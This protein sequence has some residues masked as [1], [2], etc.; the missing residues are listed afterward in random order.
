MGLEFT[1]NPEINAETVLLF[2]TIVG[3]VIGFIFAIYQVK[4]NQRTLKAQFLLEITTRYFD[5]VE[6]REFYYKVDY[7]KF[8]FDPEDN[9][10][11][12]GSEDERLLDQLLYTFDTIG[13][14][15]TSK[16]VSLSE[17]DILAFQAKRV[18]ENKSIKAYL[19]WLDSEY[20][21]ESMGRKSHPHAR[22]MVKDLMK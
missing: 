20:H 8:T 12:I 1:W 19:D 4:Q 9:Q 17:I 6:M 10:D 11:F 14:L 13:R 15:Y 21:D 2:I 16:I 18:L 7:H 22:K 3:G 5:N